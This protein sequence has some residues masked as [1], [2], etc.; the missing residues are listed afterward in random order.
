[1]ILDMGIPLGW[2]RLLTSIKDCKSRLRGG[3]GGGD[4]FPPTHSDAKLQ[5]VP[6][7]RRG[8]S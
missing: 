3:R 6:P 8:E 7:E 4:A 1:M 5:A 2:L